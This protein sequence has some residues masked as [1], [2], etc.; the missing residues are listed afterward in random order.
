M[1]KRLRIFAEK[2]T[3]LVRYFISLRIPVYASHASFF[4]ALAMFPS[5]VLLLSLLR[6]TGLDVN[7]LT[8]LLA[9]VLPK[10]LLPA[11]EKLIINT[12]HSTT[13]TLIS[14]SAIT[15][16]WTASRS[17]YGLCT[18][19][20]SIYG[21][22]EA[23]RNIYTRLLS[24]VYTFAFLLVLLLTLVLHVLGTPLLSWLPFQDSFIWQF[25]ENIVDSRFVLL[26]C[27]QSILFTVMYMFLPNKRNG[28]LESLPG[29]LMAS[30]GWLV[31]SDLYSIYVE[32]FAG[33]SNVYGSVY[34]VAL[35]LVWL[36]CCIS[37]LF[38]GGALNNWLSRG[39][40]DRK[41]EEK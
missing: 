28:F 21:V 35:S 40:S 38:Y 34:A 29:A 26:L 37:I 17:F 39:K 31:F 33:L 9:G 10:A 14:I 27:L 36:Y 7:A 11:A 15:A 22:A 41:K 1:K 30:F 2:L 19:L 6:Y 32:H 20:N 18:G 24:V 5:L 8:E 23:R 25:F 12:Y 16:L 3:G 4:I 13:G